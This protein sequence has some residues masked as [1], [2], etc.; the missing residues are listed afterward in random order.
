MGKKDFDVTKHILYSKHEVLS[1]SEE[2]KLL[3]KYRVS[4][5]QLPSI[6]KSDPGLS[7]LKVKI[8]D[9]IRIIRKSPTAGV[10]YYYRVVING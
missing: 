4:K 6:K 3:E 2:K 7:G 8:G 10:H 1:A 9:V 5:K